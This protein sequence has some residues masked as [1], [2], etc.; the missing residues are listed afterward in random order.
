MIGSADE[1]IGLCW[2]LKARILILGI[3]LQRTELAPAELLHTGVS[4]SR[5]I[6]DPSFVA[7]YIVHSVSRVDEHSPRGSKDL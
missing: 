2:Y 6:L 5:P 4:C 7:S 3:S 1:P